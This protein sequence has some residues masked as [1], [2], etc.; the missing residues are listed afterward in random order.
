[1]TA[2]RCAG[3]GA[4]DNSCK[5]IKAHVT[6]CPDFLALFKT[7][8]SK[9]LPPEAEYTRWKEEDNTEEQ[10]A[11]E[12]DKRLQVRFADMDRRRENQKERWSKKKDILADD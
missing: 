6:T 2:G 4:T 10:R 11:I 3:C 7:D 9:A 8:P 5:K 1:M 12:K